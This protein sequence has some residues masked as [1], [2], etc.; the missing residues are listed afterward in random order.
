MAMEYRLAH[1]ASASA[2]ARRI[3]ADLVT[4]RLPASRANEF[5]LMVSEVVGNAVRH[6]EADANGQIGLT[7]DSEGEV[8]RVVVTDA[9]PLEF[10]F[11]RNTFEK[12]DLNHL[13][14]LMVDRLAD[15]WGLSFDQQKAV[16]FEVVVKLLAKER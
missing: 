12:D 6:G 4:G 13:G 11:D 14:L 10:A 9:A 8:L 3:A 15:R 16:W 1:A 5:V 2:E 7:L